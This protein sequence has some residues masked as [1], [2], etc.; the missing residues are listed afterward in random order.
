MPE[1][2]TEQ[3]KADRLGLITGTKAHNLL[4][5]K[6]TRITLMAELIREFATADTKEIPQTAAMKRGSDIE[7]EAV[8]YYEFLTGSTVHG[9]DSFITSGIHPLFACS[10]DGLI[11][12]D[13]GLEIKRLDDVNHMKV[14]LSSIDKKYLNQIRWCLFVTGRDWWDYLGYCE[15]M[16]EPLT[17]HIIRFE[18][19]KC[20]MDEVE[21][22]ALE[23]VEQLEQTLIKFEIGGVL[24][25]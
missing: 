22:V 25:A 3:W 6:T 8:S 23:F 12:E 18:R 7:P 20:G 21:N 13:G 4:S 5:S 14:I 11:D 9:K 24:A 17:G 10:P 2:R 1:Q 16:P 19:E 15:T